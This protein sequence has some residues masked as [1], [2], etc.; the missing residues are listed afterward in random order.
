MFITYF[1]LEYV[2]GIKIRDFIRLIKGTV[3]E[4]VLSQPNIK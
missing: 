2:V 1:S 4:T 3:Y